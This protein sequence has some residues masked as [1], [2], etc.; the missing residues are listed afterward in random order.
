LQQI[1]SEQNV[2]AQ[3]LAMKQQLQL[4]SPEM[5]PKQIEGPTTD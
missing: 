2:E 3:L 4:T 5:S 1:T